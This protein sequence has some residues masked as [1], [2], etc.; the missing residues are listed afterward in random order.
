VTLTGT[1][2]TAP[3]SYTFNG[4]TNATGIFAGIPAGVA[5]A[6]SVT[7]ARN[8]TPGNR[9]SYRYP[10]GTITGRPIAGGAATVC[11]N[12]TTPAFY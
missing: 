11:V 8:C 10:T 5:Y 1:G 2:G 7:D 3:L 9:Y 4:I 6:W 12:A